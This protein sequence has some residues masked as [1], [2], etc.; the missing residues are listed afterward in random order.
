MKKIAWITLILLFVFWYLF[1]KVWL[2]DSET[3]FKFSDRDKTSV[4]P[5]PKNDVL[6]PFSP[7]ITEKVEAP[8][9][10][11]KSSSD[12]STIKF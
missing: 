9:I 10:E 2:K 11:I 12:T 5:T 6:D 4:F 8:T 3:D 7:S 1:S